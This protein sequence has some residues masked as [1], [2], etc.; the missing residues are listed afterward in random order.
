MKSIYK[1][2]EEQR[3]SGINTALC[4]IVSTK[5]STPLKEGAKM[6]VTETGVIF[7]TIGGGNL[8]KKTIENALFSIEENSSSI[9]EHNLLSQHGMCCGGTVK[10]FIEPIMKPNKLFIFGAGHVGRA[11][12]QIASYLDFDIFVIDERPQE[13]EKI[14]NPVINKVP[15]S[16]S[17]ILPSLTFDEKTYITILTYDHQIDREILA[18]CIKKPFAYLGMIGSKRKVEISKK[19]FL[20]TNLFTKEELEKVD[21]PMGID[22]LANQPHEIAISILAKLIEVKNQPILQK[23]DMESIHTK[24][25]TNSDE[26]ILIKK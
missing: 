14:T 26:K 15:F 24:I 23:R 18:Y 7:G 21:M 2:I 4:T 12:S 3:N 22:I 5:G 19:M 16:Y 6:L 1:I 8:E 10:I 17:E 25:E 13:M 11:L 20:S 9:F